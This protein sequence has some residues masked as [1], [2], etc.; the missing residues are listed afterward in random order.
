M[1]TC[2]MPASSSLSSDEDAGDGQ[3]RADDAKQCSKASVKRYRGHVAGLRRLG[4]A[5]ILE[6]GEVKSTI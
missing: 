5:T 6:Y 1:H 4:M 3:N 2:V